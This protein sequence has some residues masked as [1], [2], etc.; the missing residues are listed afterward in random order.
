[1]RVMQ[2]LLLHARARSATSVVI[3]MGGVAGVAWLA[4]AQLAEQPSLLLPVLDGHPVL[5]P[6]VVA[7]PVLTS[8]L[9]SVTLSGHD[10]DLERTAPRLSM[11]ARAL[12]AAAAVALAVAA[13]VA[14]VAWHPSDLGSAAATRNALGLAGVALLSGAVLPVPPWA[15]GFCYALTTYLTAPRTPTGGS[16]WWAWAVQTGAADGSWVVAM[17]L[18]IAGVAA[19]AARGPARASRIPALIA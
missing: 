1:M 4:A 6:V 17:A 8:I 18:L 7:A 2:G 19:Y 9:L 13:C 16:T 10:T 3:A 5:V 12:H 15:P 14:A 11:P